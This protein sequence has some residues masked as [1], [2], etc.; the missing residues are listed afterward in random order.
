MTGEQRDRP[1]GARLLRLYPARW[2][3]RYE[4]EML[5]VLQDARMGPAARLDLVRGALDARLH[6]SR[7]RSAVAALLAGALWTAT[8][9]SIVAQ[10]A[11]PDWPGY[12]LDALP[13]AIAAAV[14][15]AIAT[16]GCWTLASDQAPRVG[17]VALVLAVLGHLAWTAALVGAWVGAG[18]GAVTMAVQVAAVGGSVVVGLVLIQ[19]G[20]TRIGR[21]LTVGPAVMLFGWPVSWLLFGFAWTLIGVLLLD[22]EEPGEPFPANEA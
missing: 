9:A 4:L 17:A 12:Q 22:R 1:P 16:I 2:R 13:L 8:S 21:P 19:G 18:Y 10:P 3:Q 5:A 20:E 14:L 15:S 11:P 6:G 7:R